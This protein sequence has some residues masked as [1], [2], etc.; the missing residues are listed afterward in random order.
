MNT[1]PLSGAHGGF[2]GNPPSGKSNYRRAFKPNLGGGNLSN[3]NEQSPSRRVQRQR[4]GIKGGPN[5]ASYEPERKSPNVP[6]RQL[7]TNR[8]SEHRGVGGPSPGPQGN[9]MSGYNPN[10]YSMPMKGEY[11][12]LESAFGHGQPPRMQHSP[13]ARHSPA[14]AQPSQ[15][16]GAYGNR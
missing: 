5:P 16:H 4:S 3:Q 13:T 12:E 6:K 15:R 11:N 1:T 10:K 7:S 2:D 9:R 14:K 8:K